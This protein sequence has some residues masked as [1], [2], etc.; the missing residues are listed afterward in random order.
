MTAAVR[1][2]GSFAIPHPMAF[3]T[4][5]NPTSLSADD[6]DQ[7]LVTAKWARLV[8]IL[9]F[10]FLGILL[11]IGTVM[12]TFLSRLMAMNMAL[13]GGSMPFDPTMFGLFYALIFLIAV[14]IYFFPTLFLY[15]YA[16]RTM[17]AL[18]AG[19][20][21]ELFSKGI[22]AQRSFFSYIG[23][24]MIILVGLYAIGAIVIGF[25][26]AMMPSMPAVD[27]SGTGI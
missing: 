22:G 5:N 26:M 14:I 4:L 9:G 13:T 11:L 19:F 15:Q 23:I 17:R 12:S 27:P 16:T 3:S 1:Y 18:R 2:F 10:V 24:L 8:A 21:P 25:A 20:D 6:A 7:I